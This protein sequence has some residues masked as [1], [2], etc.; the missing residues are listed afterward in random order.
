MVGMHFQIN[1]WRLNVDE[2]KLYRQDREVSVE[3]RLINL[4]YFLAKN[5][6]EV[7]C[8]EQLI[9]HVWG[10]AIVTDQVVTQ[11]IFELRKLLRDGREESIHYLIT[12]PKRG[13]KLVAS[14][15][16]IAPEPSVDANHTLVDDDSERDVEPHQHQELDIGST[17]MIFPAGPLT[18]ALNSRK[19][20]TRRDKIE[21][22]RWKSIAFDVLW[23]SAL[24]IAFG[25]FTY[26]QSETNITQAMDT[27]LIEFTF[28]ETL[29]QDQDHIELSDGLVQKLAAD[30][31]QV[32]HYRVRL[33]KARFVAGVLPG[34]TVT[35]KIQD[36][37][38]H[39][40]LDV[41][42]R[43]NASGTT[44]FSRQY[45]L[46]L[47]QIR[48]VIEKASS[49]LMQALAVPDAENKASL[50][51]AAMPENQQAL[52]KL[53]RA[54]H[55]LNVSQ[56]SSFKE[57]IRLLEEALQMEPINHYLQAELLVAYYVQTALDPR[58][59]LSVD[60]ANQLTQ[61][62]LLAVDQ[63]HPLSQPRIFEALALHEII[64]DN[65]LRADAYLQQALSVRESVFGNVLLGKLAELQGDTERASEAY[66]EA[67]YMDISLETYLLCENL[68]FY[69][70]LKSIDYA[71]YRAVHPSVTTVL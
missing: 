17:D 43:N 3:P 24:I 22:R 69:S 58:Q 23:I 6:G 7:F 51:M 29:I 8:R 61:Q 47:P 31:A 56:P 26:Y 57:G 19:P 60:R 67:F 11:S 52:L 45:P 44:L 38:G 48:Q 16:E 2:N 10:G 12:V 41:E 33:S 65:P 27:H 62:L 40:Y 34:K 46:V 53:V 18:R 54:H 15:T 64:R 37:A 55:Y 4:L 35:V 49:E 68:A 30:I 32:S 9:E 71:L 59:S 36:Q 42:Y 70:N 28:Q 39:T 50:L 21:I 25:V 63:G 1:D 20:A 5:P 13:Y 66:S 14:V